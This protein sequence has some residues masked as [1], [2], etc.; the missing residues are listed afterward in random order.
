MCAVW[1]IP[2][3]YMLGSGFKSDYDLQAHPERLF[4]SAWSEWTLKHYF[5]FLIRDGK[6]D[7][8]DS[9]KSD[10]ASNMTIFRRIVCPLAKSTVMLAVLFTFTGSRN[11][12][13]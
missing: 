9:A 12:L 4:P 13:V 1:V 11:G 10:G 2:L 5:G 8:V 6:V 3:L 7:I